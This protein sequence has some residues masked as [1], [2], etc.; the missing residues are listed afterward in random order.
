MGS[1]RLGGDSMELDRAERLVAEADQTELHDRATR[2]VELASLLGDHPLLF[3]GLAA[4]WLFEDVKATWLYG[5]FTSTV[6]TAYAFCLQ[7]VAGV[8][9]IA[10]Q[11]D[12]VVGE[13]ITLE[14]LAEIAE[15][16]ELIDLDLR[17]QL[18]A[19]HDSAAIY[20][21]SDLASYRRPLDRRADDTE[22]FSEEHTLLS[23]ARSALTCCVRLVQG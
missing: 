20:L 11:D 14:T 3:H 10:A 15:Q 17:A 12:D 9:R 2:L 13:A 21:A 6:L 19:L 8:I 1:E 16:R 18:V 22:R 7:Q 4:E 5:Y 23:D